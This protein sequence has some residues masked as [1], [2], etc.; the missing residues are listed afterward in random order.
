MLAA[1]NFSNV[2]RTSLDYSAVVTAGARDVLSVD[3][4][5]CD[6][7]IDGGKHNKKQTLYFI[8]AGTSAA[9]SS[10]LYNPLDCL[11]VRWQ[12]APKSDPR[13]ARGL[14]RYGLDI[15]K[16]EGLYHG[17]W[18]P[19]LGANAAG[20][21]M[22]AAIRFGYYETV[23]D[24]LIHISSSSQKSD[25]RSSKAGAHMVLAG[26]ICGSVAYAVSTP[27]HLIKTMIQAEQGVFGPD[28][29]YSSGARI[30]KN[31][32]ANDFLTRASEIVKKRGIGCLWRGSTP[33]AARGALFTAGQMVGYDG[34]KTIAKAEGAEDGP[35]LHIMSSLAA[36]FG[37][38]LLSAPADLTMAKYM[39]KSG[40][41]LSSLSE[42]ICAIYAESGLI[43]FWRGWPLFFFRLMPVMVTYSTLYEQLRLKLG[44]GYLS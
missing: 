2:T 22:S 33:L 23:R 26:L 11:R 38:S 24:A 6:G 36:S 8:A 15:V 14:L 29:R 21:G 41:D 35:Y 19:G 43:G 27:F 3:E 20:M 25:D 32:F 18:K 39:T 9:F 5:V 10:A 31:A 17:L 12:V 44:L 40:K 30:G 16:N 37:A 7:E 28:R 1:Y 34:L 4:F 42:C 13:V